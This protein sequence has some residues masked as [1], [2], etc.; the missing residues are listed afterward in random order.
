MSPEI[1]KKLLSELQVMITRKLK[2]SCDLQYLLEIFHEELLF[3]EKS[4]L[5]QVSVEKNKLANAPQEATR[6]RFPYRNQ[7]AT[8]V[9]LYTGSYTNDSKF[10]IKCIY[11]DGDHKSRL[12]T[13]V[14]DHVVRRK[15]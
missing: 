2:G 3:R 12:C 10:V 4:V 6:N 1:L 11:C 13:I 14:T 9:T 15:I 8:A 5:S 7:Q